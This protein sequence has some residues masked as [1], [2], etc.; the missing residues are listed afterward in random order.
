MRGPAGRG[1]ETP[2]LPCPLST[3]F[4]NY[5]NVSTAQASRLAAL[6]VGQILPVFSLFA[7]CDPGAT[8]PEYVIVIV[9]RCT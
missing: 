3:A 5:G 7:P 8:A 6:L 1:S 9:T 2:G 4:H